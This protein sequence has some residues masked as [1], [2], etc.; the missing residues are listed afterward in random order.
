MEEIQPLEAAQL[1]QLFES[2]GDKVVLLD[3]SWVANSARSKRKLT[4]PATP[5]RSAVRRTVRTRT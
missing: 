2:L 5:W 4:L 1:G 3:N